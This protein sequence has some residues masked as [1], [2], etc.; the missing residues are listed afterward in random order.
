MKYL[1]EISGCLKVKEIEDYEAELNKTLRDFGMKESVHFVG[2][3]STITVT[4]DTKLNAESLG[5]IE[6]TIRGA[7]EPHVNHLVIK[8]KEI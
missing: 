4:S 2:P 7:Y 8:H 5:K 3:I 6:D 1:F